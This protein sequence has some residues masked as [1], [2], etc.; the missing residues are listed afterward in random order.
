MFKG[1]IEDY[2]KSDERKQRYDIATEMSGGRLPSTEDRM[3]NG[4]SHADRF[5]YEHDS[6]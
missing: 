3:A 6:N 4:I 5:N 2:L 1:T